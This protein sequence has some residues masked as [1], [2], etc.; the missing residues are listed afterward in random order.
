MATGHI[1]VSE[2][3]HLLVHVTGAV[4]VLWLRYLVCGL[5]RKKTFKSQQSIPRQL[6]IFYHPD[7][8]CFNMLKMSIV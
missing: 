6:I 5:S 4:N 8:L 2:L 7:I 1:T 3:L